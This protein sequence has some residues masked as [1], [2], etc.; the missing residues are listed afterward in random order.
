MLKQLNQIVS[1]FFV[2][3]I[4]LFIVYI[5]GIIVIPLFVFYIFAALAIVGYLAEVLLDRFRLKYLSQ[6]K[7][8]V[9]SL[10]Y[11]HELTITEYTLSQDK[12]PKIIIQYAGWEHTVQ[13]S[14]IIDT[15]G[16]YRI[17]KTQLNH[18]Q[19]I[20]ALSKWDNHLY[21]AYTA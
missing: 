6:V 19:F 7:M 9:S 18:T 15:V 21:M 5:S 3:S 1:I 12:T 14:Q 10:G 20:I 13:L 8:F 2:V 4:V 16:P 11:N 17:Y